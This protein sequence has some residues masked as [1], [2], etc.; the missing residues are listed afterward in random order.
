MSEPEPTFDAAP[1]LDAGTICAAGGLVWKRDGGAP[2]LAVIHRPGHDDWSLPKGKVDPGE[3][4]REAARRE[5]LEEIGCRC[6]PGAFAGSAVY[7]VKSKTK[8]VAF[9]NMAL[10]AEAPFMPNDEVDRL[11]WLG[12]EQAMARLSYEGEKRVLAEAYFRL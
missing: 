5:I 12:F 7:P 1:D 3:T 11:E 8:V 6:T 10:D 9:W 4:W 2:R